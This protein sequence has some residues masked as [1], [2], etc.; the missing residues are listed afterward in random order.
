MSRHA[1]SSPR[2]HP[3]PQALQPAGFKASW[4]PRACRATRAHRRILTPRVSV[5]QAP[6]ARAVSTFLSQ[7]SQ[8]AGF[9]TSRN[10]RSCRATCVHRRILTP[11]VSVAQAPEARAAGAFSSQASAQAGI[12]AHVAP[13]AFIAAFLSRA[14]PQGACTRSPRR[15]HIFVASIAASRLQ[16]K[17]ETARMSCHARS[18]PHSYPARLRRTCAQSPHRFLRKQTAQPEPASAGSGFIAAPLPR[19]S[20]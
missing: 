2:P 3:A 1:R 8:P 18:P 20:P 9:S 11:R 12:P 4:K 15:K 6:E 7:A 13:R 19:A 5:A 10:P 14:P 16:R 17:Q